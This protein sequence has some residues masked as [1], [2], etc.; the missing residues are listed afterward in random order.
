MSKASFPDPAIPPP[1]AGR[2][3]PKKGDPSHLGKVNGHKPAPRP[4]T[5][6]SASATGQHLLRHVDRLVL[7]LVDG[8]LLL[9]AFTVVHAYNYGHLN[10]APQHLKLLAMLLTVRL[11]QALLVEKISQLAGL[12]LRHGMGVIA[13]NGIALTFMVSLG[14]LIFQ[15]FAMSRF[16]VYGSIL[17]FTFLEM[18]AFVVYRWLSPAAQPDQDRQEPHS[19]AALA[20]ASLIMGDGLLLV[21]SV[22]AA[23][24]MKRGGFRLLINLGRVNDLRWLNRY[25]ILAHTRL[26]PGGHLVG[27]AHTATTQRAWFA[28]SSRNW[29]HPV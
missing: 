23:T 13:R 6:A 4:P 27:V 12:S 19:P 17:L 5:S 8:C 24:Y 3:F 16:L 25:F 9:A 18:A 2:A 14:L 7:A 10:V 22:V 26:Q 28:T 20:P 21:L 11:G 29:P 1:S 15:L